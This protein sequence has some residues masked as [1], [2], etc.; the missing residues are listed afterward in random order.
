MTVWITITHKQKQCSLA[1]LSDLPDP[2]PDTTAKQSDAFEFPTARWKNIDKVF[3]IQVAKA[4]RHVPQRII[5]PDITDC[6][7]SRFLRGQGDGDA[8]IWLDLGSVGMLSLLCDSGP[9]IRTSQIREVFGDTISNAIEECDLR[10]WEKRNGRIDSTKCVKVKMLCHV[11]LRIGYD[12][13][14][15][16][17][18]FN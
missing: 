3:P 14:I 8:I 16:Q 4:V 2:E 5:D 11:E 6:V 10:K 18:L 13:T 17:V 15:A 1:I 7:R 12:T 9:S